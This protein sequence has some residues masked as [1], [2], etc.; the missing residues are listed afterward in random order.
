MLRRII[1]Q[2]K[3]I[4][5]VGEGVSILDRMTREDRSEKTGR[6]KTS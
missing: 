3:E 1:K 6:N 5:D 4:G 2:E